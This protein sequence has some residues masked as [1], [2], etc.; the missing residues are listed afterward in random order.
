MHLE[1]RDPIVDD[2]GQAAG[3]FVHARGSELAE[4][5]P[6]TTDDGREK[7]FH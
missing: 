7:A 2:S 5:V 3:F 1:Q 6:S 4:D